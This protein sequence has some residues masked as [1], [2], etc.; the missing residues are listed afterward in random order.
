[1]RETLESGIENK[2]VGSRP[3]AVR[4]IQDSGK[5]EGCNVL[6]VEGNGR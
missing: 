4:Q 5:T 1:M 2:R 3:L 6:Y